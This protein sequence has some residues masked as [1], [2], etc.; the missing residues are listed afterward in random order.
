MKL[1]KLVVIIAVLSLTF[2]CEKG[3]VAQKSLTTELDSVSYGLGLDMGIKVRQ[4]FNEI[5][6]DLYVQGFLNGID[7]VDIKLDE[8]EIGAI[9][10][11]YFQKKQQA[12]MEKQFE[13]N[14]VEGEEFLAANKLKEGVQT[15]ES[16]LQYIVLKEGSG[17]KPTPENQVELHYHGMLIDGTVFDSSVEKGQPI[18]HSAVG[19]VTGFNEA[20]ALMSVGSKYKVFIPQDLAYGANPRPGGP[21][22]PYKTIIFEIELLAIK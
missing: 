16:G 1:V 18:T 4:N 12:E 2:S 3:A 10:N 13:G 14:K 5:D 17:P 21:I 11:G 20:L 15:T 6:S 7:S 8:N 9:L 22:E 19:F